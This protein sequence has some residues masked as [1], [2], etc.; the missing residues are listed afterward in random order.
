MLDSADHNAEEERSLLRQLAHELRD[1]LSPLASSADLARL[2]AFDAESARLLVDKVDR[3]LHRTLAIL[4]A[5]VLAEQCENGALHPV[6]ADVPLAEILRAASEELSER[7][8]GRCT[9]VPAEG[10]P[11]VR[12]DVSRSAKVL[13]TLLR[14]VAMASPDTPIEVRSSVAAAGGQIRIRGRADP[15]AASEAGG[16]ALRTARLFLESQ[17]GALELQKHG[18]AEFEL[19]MSFRA[20]AAHA[21]AHPGAPRGPVPSVPAAAPPR[22]TAARARRITR[23]LIV[24]DSLPVRR[25]YRDALLALGY[26]VTEAADAEQALTAL[27]AET[28]DV[29]LIDIHLPAVNGYRLAQMI[30]ERLGSSIYLVMLSGMAL[31]APSRA[32]ARQAGF[33]DCLDKMAGPIALRDLVVAACADRS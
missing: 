5:F 13:L 14:A 30:R 12:A 7:E 8:L 24:D 28:P 11:L 25:A 6:P 22:A 15:G 26:T 18:Q 2:R 19:V 21:A 16:L 3:G 31:D 4:E 32:R 9:F 29:V 27:D 1:A 17:G 20:A 23:V 10:Q 33:D